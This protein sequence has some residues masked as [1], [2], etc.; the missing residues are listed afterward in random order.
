VG[1]VINAGVVDDLGDK[2]CVIAG[3]DVDVA[4]AAAAVDEAGVV[5]H[6]CF[7]LEDEGIV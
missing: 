3:E 6:G 4:T 5:F 1:S 2:I 7:L